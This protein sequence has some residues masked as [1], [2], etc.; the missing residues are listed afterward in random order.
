MT[1]LM[2]PKT[3]PQSPG[4]PVWSGQS[5]PVALAA[6]AKAS[7]EETLLAAVKRVAEA[8]SDFSWLSPGDAVLLKP[9]SNSGNRY[10]ATTSPLAVR[11]MAGLLKEKGAG[12]V[13][14]GDKAGVQYVYQEEKGQ[15]GATRKLMRRN[16]LEQAA[17]EAGGE[18]LCFEEAGYG[19][20]FGDRTEH[21]GH[22][23][24]E[25]MLPRILT[26]VDH[27]VLLPRVSRHV[28]AGSTLG[29]KAA[30]GWLRDDS[31]LELHRDA[32]SFLAK[33]VEINDA[34]VLRQKLRL[35]LSVATKVQTTFGPDR[36]YAAEP[37][38]GLIFASAS[39]LAHD[40]VALSW[41]LWNRE[42]ETPAWQ[43]SWLKD[44]YQTYPGALNRAFVG[45]IWGA[46]ELLK[47]ETYATVP[48]VS[49]ATDP[50]LSRGSHL[51]GGLPRLEVEDVGGRLPESIKSY[52]LEKSSS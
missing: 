32:A 30:V 40:M 23:R 45:H 17:L 14:L 6:V 33:I 18:V 48:I 12:R 4:T 27:V 43:L 22:W 52:L 10:P 25:L 13:I 39:L 5:A 28:L 36:G 41:L 19:A 9:A 46:G 15:R 7:G 34:A 47:S 2:P 51:W 11:A 24:G 26:Q 21:P 1:H 35:V 20:Y 16:G 49:V 8:A 31:R 50:L 38:P 37:D 42:F 44:P 29:L 3:A